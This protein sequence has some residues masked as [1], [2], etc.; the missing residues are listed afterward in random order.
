MIHTGHRAWKGMRI[1]RNA[2]DE[3]NEKPMT[4]DIRVM[5][6]LNQAHAFRVTRYTWGST[7]FSVP[8]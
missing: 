1:G 8:S 6:R 4:K 3:G 7:Y 2:A 5:D